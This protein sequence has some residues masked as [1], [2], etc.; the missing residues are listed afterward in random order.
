MSVADELRDFVGQNFLGGSP[1]GKY[2]LAL[3]DRIEKLE[4]Q[5]DPGNANPNQ[6]EPS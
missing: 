2:L 4:A 3:A 1:R 6:E 5:A